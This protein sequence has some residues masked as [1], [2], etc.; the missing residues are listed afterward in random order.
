LLSEVAGQY[1]LGIEPAAMLRAQMELVNKVTIAQ[2][3]GA[4]DARSAEER[5]AFGGWAKAL[6]AGQLHRLWQLL[7]KG[8]EEVRGAPDPL[9][10][11]QMAL[12]RVTHA[13]TLP[14]PGA[15]VKRMEEL[16]ARPAA[17]AATSGDGAPAEPA[18]AI[19]MDWGALVEQVALPAAPGQLRAAQIMHDWVQVIALRPGVLHYQFATGFSEDMGPALRDALERATGATWEVVRTT[20]DAAPSLR[21]VAEARAAQEKAAMIG[22]PLV[23]AALAAFPGA[24]IIDEDGAPEHLPKPRSKHA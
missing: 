10:A 19:A 20:G 1:A 24:E 18:A 5:E 21:E 17:A 6:S 15:L 8:Y 9:V 11:A 14:D 22:D 23:Q 16:A 12:L 2:V 13:A 4:S 3:S 7:L